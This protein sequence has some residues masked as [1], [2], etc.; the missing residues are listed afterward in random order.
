VVFLLICIDMAKVKTSSI[1]AA[2]KPDAFFAGS[3][4]IEQGDL[5][6]RMAGM[7]GLV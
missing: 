7:Y 6:Q 1:C 5:M 2:V 4:L 3:W